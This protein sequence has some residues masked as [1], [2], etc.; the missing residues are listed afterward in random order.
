MPPAGL[1]PT[2]NA[3]WT[4]LNLGVGGAFIVLLLI[5]KVRTER[6]IQRERE[7]TARER[8]I[9]EEMRE[10][11][12]WA[13]AELGRSSDSINRMADGI[14]ARNEAEAALRDSSR[15]RRK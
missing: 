7:A 12:N 4:F 1:D 6:E 8:E 9:A 2:L 11:R 14:A 15:E 3:Y 10:Q 5:G 13:Q